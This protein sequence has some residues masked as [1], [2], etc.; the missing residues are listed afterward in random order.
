M[1]AS[2]DRILDP[3]SY[4]SEKNDPFKV[5]Q[6]TAASS[7]IVSGLYRQLAL[8]KPYLIQGIFSFLSPLIIFELI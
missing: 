1:N 7:S 4:A 6:T 8:C 5:M 2:I 3:H